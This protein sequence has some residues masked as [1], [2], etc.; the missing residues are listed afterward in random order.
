[1]GQAPLDIGA[2]LGGRSAQAG[3]N[4]GRTLFEGGIAGART[5]QAASGVSPFGTA[6]TRFADSPEAQQALLG[7][8]TGGTEYGTDT[9]R[10][11]RDTN[12]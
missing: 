3:A 2:Q 5:T 4:V 10:Y 6:L 9:R 7:M 8:F 11:N 12:F 1:L